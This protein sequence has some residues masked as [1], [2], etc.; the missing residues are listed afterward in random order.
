MTLIAWLKGAPIAELNDAGQGYVSLRYTE[1]AIR[2]HGPGSILLSLKLPVRAAPYPGTEAKYFL[3]GLLPEDHVR[4]ALADRARV[5]TEDT[6]GLLKAYGLD[7]A[8]AI[9]V[10]EP[11]QVPGARLGGVHWLAGSELKKA[12]SDLPAAPLG[13]DVDPGVRSSLGGLQGKLA[14]VLESE[15]VGLP[16]DGTPSTHILK[17][18]RLTDEGIERWPGIAA[19]E[20]FAMRLTFL[21]GQSKGMKVRAAETEVRD[22]MGRTAI[23]VKRFDRRGHGKGLSRIHQEDFGQA[24]GITEKYQN[25]SYEMPRLVDIAQLLVQYSTG[26][27]MQPLLERLTLGTVLGDCDAHVRNHSVLLNEGR[28]E[29]S[30]AYDMVPTA[31]WVDHSRELA[32][33]IGGEIFIDDVRGKNLVDE[34]MSWGMRRPA[35]TTMI[36]RALEVAGTLMPVLLAES[37]DLGW[38]H[39]VLGDVVR[40]AEERIRALTHR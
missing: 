6:Y 8:G 36:T 4:A 38:Y 25:S 9:Q 27:A 33:R 34:A 7:C 1:E 15:R 11:D 19:A 18:A 28:V 2:Q 5:S 3:D 14:V 16:V 24:L 26:I 21:A 23:L 30:P 13:I 17:P 35:A 20:H 12:I 39:P 32:L 29:L 40:G 22:I 10:T 31:A 37:K